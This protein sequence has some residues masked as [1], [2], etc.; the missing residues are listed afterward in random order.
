MVLFLTN[1]VTLVL[2]AQLVRMVPLGQ[3]VSLEREDYLALW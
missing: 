2:L 1:R 3:E